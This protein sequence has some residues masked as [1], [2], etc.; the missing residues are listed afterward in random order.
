MLQ[1]DELLQTRATLLD[2][3]KQWQDQVSWQEFFDIYWKLLYSVA[4]KAGLTDAE[5]KDAVQ[6]TL[7][8]V[9][10]SM[11]AFKYDPAIGSFRGW[12][13]NTARWRIHDQFRKRGTIKISEPL[14]GH[15][16]TA[17]REVENLPDP[18]SLESDAE[19]DMEWEK[20]LLA[21]ALSRV[22][23]RLDP[24][25]FQIFDFYV[26]KEWSAEKVARTFGVSVSQVYLAKHR[27]TETIKEEVKRLE[28]EVT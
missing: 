7:L 14:P 3:M 26:N 11:P 21:A 20:N 28:K 15:T 9:A 5:A 18:A 24:Q 1:E 23:R 2:R 12:L 25:K 16:A 8:S 27:V 17:T 19:W 4:R 22:R 13:L 6:D 10:K